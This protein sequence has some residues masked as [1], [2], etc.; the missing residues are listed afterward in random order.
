MELKM[1][2][3][4]RRHYFVNVAIFEHGKKRNPYLGGGAAAWLRQVTLKTGT[5]R[6][7]TE[8]PHM[9]LRHYSYLWGKNHVFLIL[10]P[11]A[12]I[13]KSYIEN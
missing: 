5:N 2:P 7:K 12:I 3:L 13:C 6:F 8:Q 10:L 11:Y 4:M 9:T 1:R